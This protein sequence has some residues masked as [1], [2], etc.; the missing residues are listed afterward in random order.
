MKWGY[1]GSF[2]GLYKG[3]VGVERFRGLGVWGFGGLGA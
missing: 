3:T 2:K 1:R